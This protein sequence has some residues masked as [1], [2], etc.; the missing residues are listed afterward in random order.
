[1]MLRYQ[2]KLYTHKWSRECGAHT[3]FFDLNG[4][5][6]VPDPPKGELYTVGQM[7]LYMDPDDM[8]WT[9]LQ[10]R[11]ADVDIWKATR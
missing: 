8:W 1:M 5:A 6:T 11:L 7:L 3:P 2:M 4:A 10:A 9:D